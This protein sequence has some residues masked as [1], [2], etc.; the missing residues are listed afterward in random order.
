MPKTVLRRGT[1]FW[2]TGMATAALLPAWLGAWR[3]GMGPGPG[4]AHAQQRGPGALV[5]APSGKAPASG[6]E[7]ELGGPRRFLTALSSDKQ[8]YRPGETVWVRGVLLD[9][10]TRRPLPE[11]ARPAIEVRGPRGE[12]VAAGGSVTQ[13]SV[14][15]FSWTV[16]GEAAGGEYTLRVTYPWNGHA[17]AERKFD[18]RV[19]RAPRLK[20]Q[21]TFARDGYGPGDKVTATAE[22]KRAE[23][24]FPVGAKVTA[25]ALVDGTEVARVPATV[26]PK[27]LCTVSFDLP[28]SIARGEGALAFAIEDGGVVETASKTIPIL[29]QTLD[30]TLY[31]EGGDLAAD[32]PNRVY[33]QALTPARKPADVEGVVVDEAG[34]EVARVRSE[35]EGR[36]RFELVPVAGARY[37]LRLT[38]PSGIKTTWTLPEAQVGGVS[39]RAPREV[40]APGA[41]VPVTVASARPRV[42]TLVLAQRER[43]LGTRTVR[44]SGGRASAAEVSLS[45]RD[46]DGVLT[47]TAYGERGEPLAERLVF[48]QP[49]RALQIDV[50][51]D[52]SSYVPGET[53]TLTATATRGGRPVSAVIGLTVT[54]D[55]V[56]QL[57]ERREQAPRLPVMVLLEPEVRELA[58]A[59]VYLD[60]RNA[61]APRALDLLLGTQGWRRFALQDPTAFVAREGD[62]ARRALALRLQVRQEIVSA[63][64][65]GSA[66]IGAVPPG[67]GIEPRPL[68]MRNRAAGLELDFEEAGVGRGGA[69]P[70]PA[71]LGAQPGPAG[72]R[73]G[74][75]RPEPRPVA[76]SPAV[77][78][79][80]PVPRPAP[81]EAPLAPSVASARQ[82]MENAI[83]K[84]E[85]ARDAQV[86]G[87]KKRLMAPQLVYVR[88]YAHVAPPNRRPDERTDFTE[89]V[90]WSAGLRTASNGQVKVRF[91]LNDSVT[92]FKVFAEGFSNDGAVAVGTGTIKAV[93][94]FYAEP[95]LP[96]E[97][98][99]GD[100]IR[101]PL[102]LVNGTGET[103]RGATAVLTSSLPAG[104][105]GLDIGKLPA[106]DL[107]PGER[108]RRLVDVAVG[109]V[110]GAAELT[111]TVTANPYVDVVKRDLPIKPAGFPAQV[112][113]GGLTARDG[114]IK[115]EVALPAN[116]VAGS[117]RT[118]VQVYPTPLANLTQALARL[119]REPHGCFEQTSSTTYPLTMAQQYFKTHSGVDP[120]L[121]AA[122]DEKLEAGYRKLTSFEC[123]EKGYEWFG[124]NPGHEALTAYGLLHFAD[125]AQVREVD[126]NMLSR[127]RDWLLR[128]RDGKG[129]FS[130]KRRALHTWVEDPDASNGYILWALLEGAQAAGQPAAG[131]EREL[132]AFKTAA[133]ASGNSYV[134]AL[135]ANV[136]ALAGER[137]AG[138]ALLDKLAGRQD[139]AGVVQGATTS[140]V[141]S[142]GQALAI[143]TTALA[144]L[145]WLR[146]SAYAGPVEKA[147]KFLADACQD[148]R[149]GSTQS[150]VLALR[151]IVAYDKARARPRAPGAVSLLVAGKP[152]GQPVRFDADT[153]GVI[154]LP[155]LAEALRPGAGNVVELRMQ[156]GSSMPYSLAVEYHAL[157][158]VSAPEAQLGLEVKLSRERVSEGELVEALA[159][160]TNRSSQAVPTPVAIVGLPGGLE[161]RHDQLKELV[162]KRTIDAYEVLGR[163]VVL[164]WRSLGGGQKVN[165]PLSLLAAIPGR[166]TGPASRAYLYYT[167]EHKHWVDGLRVEIAAR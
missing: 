105:D 38:Q 78:M 19:Y 133:A 21:I 121:I 30:L 164:Y 155:S 84:E 104:P 23:G 165:V 161:P 34:R 120:K 61:K 97:V 140:I 68:P 111:L 12:Q 8:I 54:D 153:Q 85:I 158:P 25:T 115:H 123:S 42:V 49:R 149:Y 2:V 152:V 9:A 122:A 93:Q 94:P 82:A 39:L 5:L 37:T 106:L 22:V 24:G 36:G 65:A 52:K 79:G 71:A 73:P 63:V 151:A 125:L 80:A 130:R 141:G 107:R 157:T 45:A 58:D 145:A 50:R 124:E 109:R 114:G 144:V 148:G 163:D 135:G 40:V 64:K 146:D 44:L 32:V 167:D 91:A 41:P 138:K 128:Q 53:V 43:A 87:E 10:F 1:L 103:L 47:V 108:A 166:Y 154:E 116:L 7:A 132:A 57:I 72:P 27:G 16:P 129:G 134:T 59:H 56:L 119:I 46:A 159:T 62:P 11:E 90:Y 4:A 55:S 92:A 76:A 89:T 81:A 150:T 142:G 117:L 112:T 147:M 60:P 143:E 160:V 126:A 127:S 13:D 102:A 98:T 70:P 139:K 99:Q 66:G 101:L 20:T 33:F 156:G 26:G 118:S 96:L 77:P 18:V 137:A 131:L 6:R 35:H 31:P 136:L 51:S 28:R 14:W 29:L 95:K 83:A 75:A 88:Q 113:F 162:K 100:V 110:A 15:A 69:P 17:P 3:G 48:R 67:R 86:I 74:A